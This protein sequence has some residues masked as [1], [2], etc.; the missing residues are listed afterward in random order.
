MWI[1]ILANGEQASCSGGLWARNWV[2][3]SVI[4]SSNR[5]FEGYGIG[6]DREHVGVCCRSAAACL[7]SVFTKPNRPSPRKMAGQGN[8]DD[9]AWW[10]HQYS[11]GFLRA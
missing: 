8:T 3:I 2:I 5:N 6:E 4:D 1:H 9:A 11:S 10:R 7:A